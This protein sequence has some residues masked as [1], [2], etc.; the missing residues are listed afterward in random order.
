MR[1]RLLKKEIVALFMES[2]LYFDLLLQE[3]LELVKDH[4]RRFSHRIPRLALATLANP[5][6]GEDLTG[7]AA[8]PS[9]SPP[10]GRMI[11]GF[12]PP[13]PPRVYRR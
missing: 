10:T 11:V 4:V 12:T 9:D 3:R 1:L 13:Q 5:A 8:T 6:Q 2:P 7:P